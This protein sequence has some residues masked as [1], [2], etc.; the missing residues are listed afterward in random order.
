MIV[1]DF[2]RLKRWVRV[3]FFL[4][5]STKEKFEKPL[6]LVEILD[7]E[8]KQIDW[9]VYNTGKPQRLKVGSFII[10]AEIVK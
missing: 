7:G 10:K 2:K 6:V 4:F 8:D 1:N 5:F 3:W 9:H